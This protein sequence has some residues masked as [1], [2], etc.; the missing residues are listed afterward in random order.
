MDKRN[1]STKPVEGKKVFIGFNLI[2]KVLAQP[3]NFNK[4]THFYEDK[5]LILELIVEKLQLMPD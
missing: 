5:Y 1:G 3:L 4:V 2:L